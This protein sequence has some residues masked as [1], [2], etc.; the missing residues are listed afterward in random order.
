MVSKWMGT[1]LVPKRVCKAAL[2]LS[3]RRKSSYNE[4]SRQSSPRPL[5]ESLAGC[6]LDTLGSQVGS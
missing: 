5:A 2:G 4:P 1:K 6:S 3:E